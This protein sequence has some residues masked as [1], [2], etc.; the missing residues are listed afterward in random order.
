MSRECPAEWWVPAGAASPAAAAAGGGSPCLPA[1]AT[2]SLTHIGHTRAV[3]TPGRPDGD[4]AQRSARRPGRRYCTRLTSAAGQPGD[5]RASFAC[6][7]PESSPTLV[8]NILLAAALLGPRLP[9]QAPAARGA[10][11]A[12]AAGGAAASGVANRPS[13]VTRIDIDLLQHY[14]RLLQ[15]T[16]LLQC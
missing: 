8:V 2:H 16:V 1:P 4:A 5:A 13:E 15:S 7:R 6:A 12:R 14:D 10:G 3:A 11:W 9:V